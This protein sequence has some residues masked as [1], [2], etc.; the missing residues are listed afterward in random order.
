MKTLGSGSILKRIVITFGFAGICIAI[1]FMLATGW[2][3]PTRAVAQN[4][5]SYSTTDA[6]KIP[7]VDE[8]GNS[9]FVH[10][11]EAVKPVVVNIT[12]E[13]IVKGHQGI[14]FDVFD[15]GPFFGQPPDKRMETPHVTQGGSGIIIDLD[16]HIL[17]NN[18]VVA[19]AEEITVKL[20]DGSEYSAKI[21]G[22]DAETDV[23]L[24]KLDGK[25][26]PE[27][28]AKLG[29]SDKIRIG[30]WAIAVGNPFGL[31]WTVTVGVISARGRSN[32]A[33]GGATGP[34]YQDFIQTDAS[35]NFGNSGGPLLNIRGEVIGINTAI[36][37]S[38]QGIG[39]AIPI[40]LASKVVDQLKESGEVRRGYLGIFPSELD[41]IKREALGIDE[42]IK[43]IFV[44]GVQ[45]DTPADE[46]GLR[47]GEVILDVDGTPVEDVTGFRFL[48]A[49]YP[50][51]SKVKLKV[52]REGKSKVITFTLAE[53]KEFVNK[54]NAPPM[55]T[56]QLWLG[57][58]VS[59]V[60]GVL[61]KRLGLEDV[62][63]VLVVRTIP[64]TPA[65]G[66]LESG[67][68]IVEVGGMVIENMEDYS[69][70]IEKL[71]DR[72]KAI[73]FWIYRNGLRTFVPIRP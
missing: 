25:V 58:E 5:N 71:K 45:E 17:T 55:K 18:H 20:A 37:A 32:L 6:N 4:P 34:S 12:A 68:V 22:S 11:A 10:V 64:E 33:I 48:I 23:A 47:G 35:I 29:D 66:L 13:K 39:F 9:P 73:P 44:D 42:D 41:E 21:I 46:G 52:W 69:S 70:A 24:I 26:S 14:P 38:A 59:P 27:M 15:W 1:G 63:G 43:G 65:S 2:E 8:E 40:N 56:E 54:T 60:D 3:T 28:V 7:L 50:P 30:E 62:K 72:Q 67:D 51:N 36:N 61:G 57:I 31:D 53:R 19:D 49:D 16:G